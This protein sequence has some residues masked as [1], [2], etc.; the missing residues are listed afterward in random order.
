MAKP[1]RATPV[2]TG[3]AGNRFLESMIKKQDSKITKKEIELSENVKNF[4]QF[5]REIMSFHKHPIF[6]NLFKFSLYINKY[7]IKNPCNT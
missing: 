7:E 3:E 1:I 2:L 5:S 6:K 4:I